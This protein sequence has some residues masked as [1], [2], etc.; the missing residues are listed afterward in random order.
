VKYTYYG[1]T[2]FNG[3]VNFDDYVR[4]DSGFNNHRTGWLNGDFDLNGNVNFDDY[5]L[6]DLAFNTQARR[7]D[8]T[9]P[10]ERKKKF[11]PAR[12][13]RA[14]CQGTASAHSFLQRFDVGDPGPQGYRG[15]ELSLHSPLRRRHVPRGAPVN[16]SRERDALLTTHCRLAWLA[17]FES[18]RCY[19]WARR[20]LAP[21]VPP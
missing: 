18:V 21:P 11:F 9:R 13:S 6:I 1:D 8:T 19:A 4:T 15:V 5:V 10:G 12:T 20:H 2:D 7:S 16:S 3:T 17:I 14:R